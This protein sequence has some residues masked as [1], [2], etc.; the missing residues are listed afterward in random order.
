MLK[1]FFK[2]CLAFQLQLDNQKR[3]LQHH[4]HGNKDRI[5]KLVARVHVNEQQIGKLS[6]N[7]T[8]EI[9]LLESQAMR[10]MTSL[11]KTLSSTIADVSTKVT[12]VSNSTSTVSS[13]VSTLSSKVDGIDSRLSTLSSFTNSVS[14]NVSSLSS[15][16]GLQKL[17]LMVH[18]HS[19]STKMFSD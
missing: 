2:S 16:A 9:A 4:G 1:G 5:D 17:F 14:S 15:E 11:S 19:R 12:R 13:K 3:N 7:I 6:K 8:D 18:S 10:N